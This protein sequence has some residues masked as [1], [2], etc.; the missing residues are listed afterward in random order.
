MKKV[1]IKSYA[2]GMVRYRVAKGVIKKPTSCEF[3]GTITK[4]EGAHSDYSKPLDVKWLCIPCHRNYDCKEKKN[5]AIPK[6]I[7]RW[8]QFTG[9]K[10]Q[11]LS[12]LHVF[13]NGD[14]EAVN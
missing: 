12:E 14:V 3:C 8:Q 5:G 7:E 1:A 11:C 10:A 9:K 13:P 4:L 6:I 2:D